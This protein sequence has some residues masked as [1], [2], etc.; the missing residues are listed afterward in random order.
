MSLS[1]RSLRRPKIRLEICRC[2]SDAWGLFKPH[3]Y[4]S[5]DLSR[6]A[7]CFI[8]LAMGRAVAFAGVLPCPGKAGASRVSRV[9]VL[10]DWQGIGIGRAFCRELGAL[11][12]SQGRRLYLRTSH[13]MMIRCLSADSAWDV[14]AFSRQGS[15][16]EKGMPWHKVSQRP[17][18]SFVY[19][20]GRP[21]PPAGP[22]Q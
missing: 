1:R 20:G 3:H 21:T 18:V 2:L 9:V 14:A 8:G 17:G 10:P 4:L 16:P 5:S 6:Q 11:Y 12:Q 7:R 22:P 15:H 13:T 19:V